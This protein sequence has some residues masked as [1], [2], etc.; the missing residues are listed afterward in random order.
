MSNTYVHSHLRANTG[1]VSAHVGWL[2]VICP[3]ASRGG[4]SPF[5][6]VLEGD[7]W[8]STL[9]DAACI[10]VGLMSLPG[11]MEKYEDLVSSFETSLCG[12]G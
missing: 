8:L 4:S 11:R 12:L 7:G 5:L 1:G 3:L 6:P 10:M 2:Q 9:G